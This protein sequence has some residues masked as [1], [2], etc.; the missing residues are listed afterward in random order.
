MFNLQFTEP[1]LIFKRLAPHN[2]N[3]YNA[4]LRPRIFRRR[5]TPIQLRAAAVLDSAVAAIFGGIVP[6]KCSTEP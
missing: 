4:H 1:S 2:E 6:S 5:H 3:A